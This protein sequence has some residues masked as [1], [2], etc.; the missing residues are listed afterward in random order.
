[1]PVPPV[2]IDFLNFRFP[3]SLKRLLYLDYSMPKPVSLTL[4][5]ISFK[6]FLSFKVMLPLI[7]NFKALAKRISTIYYRVSLSE[8][9]MMGEG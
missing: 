6:V 1:M 7:V 8:A 2:F 5:S 3:K 4:I 9:M